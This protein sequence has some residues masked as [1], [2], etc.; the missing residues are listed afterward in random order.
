ME[1][2]IRLDASLLE[3]TLMGATGI[4][5][6]RDARASP[7]PSRRRNA[8][9]TYESSSKRSTFTARTF[10]G[11]HLLAISPESTTSQSLPAEL[12][13][14]GRFIVLPSREPNDPDDDQHVAARTPDNAACCTLLAASDGSRPAHCQR[15]FPRCLPT[16]CELGATR[17]VE[18]LGHTLSPGDL[19]VS[20][21]H[22]MPA[23]FS[24]ESMAKKYRRSVPVRGLT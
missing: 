13:T 6:C 3:R 15:S 1:A 16:G 4:R 12:C 18:R 7:E 8:F 21:Y 2:A 23:G 20:R 19:L 11:S 22:S 14:V 10:A 9:R 24:T 5:T 17:F